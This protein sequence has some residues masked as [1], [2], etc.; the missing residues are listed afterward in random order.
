MYHYFSLQ[1]SAIQKTI[2]RHDRLWSMSGISMVLSELNEIILPRISEQ[3]GNGTVLV[4]GG[5]K[6]TARFDTNENSEKA[7]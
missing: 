7:K 4:A 1:Y 2:L 3:E 6:F 5:G